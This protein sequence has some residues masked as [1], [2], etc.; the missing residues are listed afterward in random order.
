MTKHRSQFGCGQGRRNSGRAGGGAAKDLRA[1]ETCRNQFVTN[2]ACIWAA[3]MFTWKIIAKVIEN[4]SEFCGWANSCNKFV[5][6]WSWKNTKLSVICLWKRTSTPVAAALSKGQG[7]IPP[8]FHRS[9]VSLKL[10]WCCYIRSLV[11]PLP[12]LPRHARPFWR[13]WLRL[14]PDRTRR[15]GIIDTKRQPQQK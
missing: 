1:M 13:P 12:S 4:H 14:P 10:P 5:S 8:S 11:P 2:C 3:T 15:C 7:A 9:P 6:S